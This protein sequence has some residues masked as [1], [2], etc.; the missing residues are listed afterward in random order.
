MVE[1]LIKKIS[2][3]KTPLKYDKFKDYYYVDPNLKKFEEREKDNYWKMGIHQWLFKFENGYGASV[4]KHFGSYGFDDDLFELAV[5]KFYNE[6]EWHLNYET[7]VTNNVE[8]YLTNDD[9]LK[10]LDEIQ[11]LE[12]DR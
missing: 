6:K 5:I 4:V 7:P 8:G 9:V 10:M 3:A 11:R 12:N 2:E 1:D